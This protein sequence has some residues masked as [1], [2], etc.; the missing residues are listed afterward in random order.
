ML[1][2]INTG[3]IYA[4]YI[5]SSVSWNS[6]SI[7]GSNITALS[8]I[9]S[10]QIM[11]GSNINCHWYLNQ[12]IQPN[13]YNSMSFNSY[14]TSS[15]LGTN[16][17]VVTFWESGAAYRINNETLWD[18]VSD[19]RLKE[20]ISKIYDADALDK[21]L[22]LN[23]VSYNFKIG[24]K[25]LKHGFIAQEVSKVFPNAVKTIPP[26]NIEERELVGDEC[27]SLNMDLNP[28]LVAAIKNL[29][30]RIDKL[31]D[32]DNSDSE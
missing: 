8:N 17:N 28:W 11:I 5:Q 20:N 4:D 6:P 3:Y 22:Q 1:G 24:D 13:G 30:N 21:I 15:A 31:E 16:L 10:P 26:R 18:S 25:Q 12:T 29:N 19:E 32:L 7:L 23:P 27:L 9:M 14:Y 2:T